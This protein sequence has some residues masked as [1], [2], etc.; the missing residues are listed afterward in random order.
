MA[1][2][3][4]KVRISSLCAL[5]GIEGNELVI[6]IN[7]QLSQLSFGNA[8]AEHCNIGV[9]KFTTDKKDILFVNIVK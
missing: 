7:P 2:I 4:D 1:Y 9:I 6:V 3:T 8:T 5:P